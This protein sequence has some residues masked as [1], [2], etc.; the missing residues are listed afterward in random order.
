MSTSLDFATLSLMDALDLAVLIEVEAYERYKLFSAQL[1]HRFP[2]DAASVFTFMAENEAK[3]G[4]DLAERRKAKFGD[5]PARVTRSEIYDVEAPNVGAART[6]M[7][8][9]KAF[10]LCLASEKKALSFYEEALP[11]VTDPDIKKLFEE[12]CEEEKEHVELIQ[13]AI[14]KLPPDAAEEWEDDE[15]DL[16]ML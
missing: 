15:D 4:S 12:L 5:K 10:E 16:P 14:A 7:S 8:T 13:N 11:Y 9:L 2:G 6:N 1:G 3:H